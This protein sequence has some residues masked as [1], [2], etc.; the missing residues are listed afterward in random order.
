MIPFDRLTAFFVENLKEGTGNKTANV[1]QS[2][3]AKTNV[4]TY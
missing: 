1:N 2:S 3:S 4:A